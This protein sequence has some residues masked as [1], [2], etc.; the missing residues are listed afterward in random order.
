MGHK[1]HYYHSVTKEERQRA[2]RNGN[3]RRHGPTVVYVD[4]KPVVLQ[5]VAKEMGVEFERLSKRVQRARAAGTP[6]TME[7]IRRPFPAWCKTPS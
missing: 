3:A 5:K 2:S 1:I 4:G 6:I 7:L